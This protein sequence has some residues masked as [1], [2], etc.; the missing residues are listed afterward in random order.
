MSERQELGKMDRDLQV[1]IVHLEASAWKDTSGG[2]CTVA[3][4]IVPPV[5]AVTASHTE[6]LQRTA[7]VNSKW[8]IK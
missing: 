6:N 2:E 3:L 8:F 5:R 7:I 1:N 4:H